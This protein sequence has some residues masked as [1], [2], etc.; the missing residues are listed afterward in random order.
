MKIETLGDSVPARPRAPVYFHPSYMER[1][2][3]TELG[4]LVCSLAGYLRVE[5]RPSGLEVV[6]ME[7][8][9]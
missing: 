9:E 1:A 8:I 4:A 3:I 5:R 7:F 2:S 6:R